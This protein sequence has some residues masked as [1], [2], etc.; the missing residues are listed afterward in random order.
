LQPSFNTKN[1]KQGKPLPGWT[2]ALSDM[3]DIH[4]MG[5][6][7]VPLLQKKVEDIPSAKKTQKQIILAGKRFKL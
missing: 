2:E 1:I 5:W 6:D 4:K 3:P 7:I